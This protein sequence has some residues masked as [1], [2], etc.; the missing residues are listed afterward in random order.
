MI[1]IKS[2]TKEETSYDKYVQF[3]YEG[4]SYSVLLHWDKWDGFDLTFTELD[5]TRNWIDAPDW[6]ITWDENN[7]ES[8]GYTLDQL[9]DEAIE[10][11]YL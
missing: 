6:A 7:E 11:S 9:T 5:R 4:E 2:I 10:E 1:E 8:L 3:T